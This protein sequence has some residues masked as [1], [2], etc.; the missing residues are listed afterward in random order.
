MTIY[1]FPDNFKWGS[2]TSAHQ[3]E[4]D[5]NNDWSEWESK[6]ANLKAQKAKEKKWPDHILSNYPNPL[7]E[8]NY[9]SGKA[10]DSYN[11]YEEDFDIAEKLNQNIHRF[12]IEWS[13]IEPEEGRFNEK[14]MQHYINVVKALKNRGI[15][16]MITLWHFT[17][18]VWF[19]QKGGFLN[20][21]SPK[22]FTRYVK[23]VVKNL[24][25][26]VGLWITFN[27]A[28]TVYSGHSYLKGLWPPQHTN[29]LEWRRVNNNI[30][31]AHIQTYK[32]IKE[33]Y[34]HS[35]ANLESFEVEP[36]RFLEV[37][38]R[39]RATSHNVEVGI[40]ESNSFNPSG[41]S[42]YERIIGR[43]YNYYRNLFFLSAAFPYYDFIGLNYYN[44]DRK[45]PGSYK[46]VP[47]QD[48]YMEDMGWEI[49]PKGIWHV[50]GQLKKFKK[51]IYITENGTA[52]SK[53]LVR[54]QYIKEHLK[55]VWRAIQDGV[56]VQG[57]LYWSLLDNF[58][59]AYGFIPRFG[60]VEVDFK[61]FERRIRPSALEYARI[62]KENTLQI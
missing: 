9:I 18:P 48:W 7:Q 51:P 16:P 15:E 37:Q 17:N 21:D 49:Y 56:E 20:I 10:C 33:I 58:E 59:W 44:L 54:E 40:A 53:D 42:F 1:K 5:N 2:A 27:E 19:A 50:L 13:R 41:N 22:Y 36:Q 55:W 14:E 29:I 35:P 25:D 61:I 24:K 31:R 32:A 45:V 6:N 28:T 52:D 8:E 39:D 26:Q 62:C 47:K 60:L 4:G 11:R 43:V 38:P 30:V 46:S 3:I 57:Y 12:S 23:F 34:N